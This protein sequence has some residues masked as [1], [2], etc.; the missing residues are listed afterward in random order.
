M[1]TQ[2]ITLGTLSVVST[3]SSQK[4]SKGF[5]HLPNTFFRLLSIDPTHHAES[6]FTLSPSRNHPL[7][8]LASN[9]F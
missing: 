6:Y 9:P 5:A 1:N 4:L 2:N 8:I 3:N 7:V